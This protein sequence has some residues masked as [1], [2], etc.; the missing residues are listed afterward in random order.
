[1]ITNF[2]ILDH[3][4]QLEIVKETPLDYHCTCPVCGDGGFKIDKKSGKY[5]GF[6]CECMDTPA[7]KKAVINAIAPRDNNKKAIRPKQIR[8]W[9]YRDRSGQPLVRVCREDFGDGR[10]PKRWQEHWDGKQWVSGTKGV[11]REDIPIYRYQE[12]K[13]A[14][15]EGAATPSAQNQTIFIAEGEPA[16]DALWEL[17]LPATTNIGGAGKWKASDSNDLK[18][19]K[20]VLC[21][22]R[23]QPG[24]KHI[25]AIAL[26]FPDAQWLYAFPNSPFWHNLPA[27]QGLDVADWIED[28]KLTAADIWEAV[29]PR[30]EGLPN[31]EVPTTPPI[32]EANYIQK[33][34][35]DLYSNKPW[36][37][38]NGKLC[39]WNGN[40]YQEAA[41]ATEKQRIS[42][43]CNTTPVQKGHQ[44]TYAYATPSHVENIWKWLLLNKGVSPD[45]VNPPGFNCLNGVVKLNWNGRKASWELAPHDP[46]VIYTYVSEIKFDPDA[47]PTD[48]DR[49]LSCLEPNQQQLFIQTMAAS[50]DLGTIRKYR[51]RKVKALLCKG[52]GNNGK[53]TLRE[54]VSLLYGGMGV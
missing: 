27:R 38:L 39:F 44:L 9:I 2:S 32:A 18:G 51:G 11:K 35:S 47:D 36:I 13:E 41:T 52:H 7:G 46:K 33:C 23:D 50:L 10:T 19:A 22:D 20:V 42:Q 54:A 40:H 28:Q 16:C 21:P 43:W 31:P 34:L 15:T 4:N 8:T 37:A 29:E 5:S 48:C 25:E 30:R 3:L 49:M 14:L 12:I 17:G 1:M 24:V 45:E 6:K 53:D 26:Y